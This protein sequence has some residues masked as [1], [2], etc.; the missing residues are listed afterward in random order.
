[1]DNNPLVYLNPVSMNNCPV[2]VAQN[3]KMVAIN[4]AMEIDLTGQC[5]SESIGPLQYSSTGAAAD[6]VRGTWYSKGG[7]SFM[8]LHST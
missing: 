7:K 5:C 1:M 8:A 2:T 4:A 6:F 3:D